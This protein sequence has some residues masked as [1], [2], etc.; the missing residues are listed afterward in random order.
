MVDC[1]D[2]K[3]GDQLSCPDCGLVFE[4]KSTCTNHCSDSACEDGKC[5]PCSFICCGKELV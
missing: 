2:L 5:D 4:V 3:V 1:H